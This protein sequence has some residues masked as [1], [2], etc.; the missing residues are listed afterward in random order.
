MT[1]LIERLEAEIRKQ[2]RLVKKSLYPLDYDFKAAYWR[3]L[4]EDVVKE[5]RK[6]NA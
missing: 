1:N 3:D 4:L 2:D 6:V 5:M